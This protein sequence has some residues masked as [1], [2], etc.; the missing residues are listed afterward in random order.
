MNEKIRVLVNTVDFFPTISEAVDLEVPPQVDGTYH[1]HGEPNAL[2]S[3][4]E[5]VV[6]AVVGFAADGFPIFGRFIDD[7]ASVREVVPSYRL[8][9]GNRPSGAG[10]P[11]GGFDGTFRDDYEFVDGLGDLDVR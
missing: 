5:P 11:G 7:N 9:T 8:K 1:Y 3:S 4:D 10:Q 2:Y 6:F